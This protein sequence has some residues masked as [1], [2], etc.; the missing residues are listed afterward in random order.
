MSKRLQ[1]VVG[2]ESDLFDC[3]LRRFDLSYEEGKKNFVFVL[4]I[5][6]EHV[7]HSS[8]ISQGFFKVI[9]SWN[10]QGLKCLGVVLSDAYKLDVFEIEETP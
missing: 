8:S 7:P 3:E 9:E 6:N 5:P 10:D 4:T 1:L 2:S